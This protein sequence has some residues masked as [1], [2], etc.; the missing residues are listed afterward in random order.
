[1]EGVT[2]SKQRAFLMGER[3]ILV[4][5]VSRCEKRIS[6]MKANDSA[7]VRPYFDRLEQLEAMFDRVQEET[8]S[9]NAIV[10]EP[11]LLIETSKFAVE[12]WDRID[13]TRGAY[14]S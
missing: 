13:A 8:K 1:M 4:E 9:F 11:D 5:A 10:K 3:D 6:S 12:F 14:L 2:T 7:S